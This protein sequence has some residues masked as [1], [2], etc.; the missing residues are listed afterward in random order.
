MKYVITGSL[1]HI[2]KPLTIALVKAGK[3]VTVITH[4][5]DRIKDI[6][7]LGAKAAV[8]SPTDISF[9]KKTFDGA[10][11]VYTMAPP[12]HDAED[13]VATIAK[14][15]ESY[16]AAL[17][18]STVKYVVNLSSIGAHRSHGTGPV[19]GIHLVEQSLN[20]L[21]NIQ[22]KHLRPAY[23]YY[24]LFS[25][26]GLIKNMGIMG[27]NF[28]VE[29]NKFPI[30]EPAD[31]ADAAAE[32]L[33]KL[34]FTG[35]SVRYVASDE[36]STDGIAQ[37]IGAALGKKDLAWVKFSD[38]Q[39][40]GGMLQAGLAPDISRNYVEMGQAIHNGTM[41]EDYW[42]HRPKLGKTKLEDFARAFAGVYGQ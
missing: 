7:S 5:N 32:E 16:A 40:L 22:I 33:L 2:S 20:K 24:N 26:I 21:A 30:V 4:N 25:N 23:F 36:V 6:E 29:G 10:D 14:F 13:V 3:D 27:S 9:L 39:A 35:H 19:N 37:T 28:S 31:I 11:A 12:K 34:D 1:G 41:S 38:E 8:G 18:D 15:G 17:K 42:Q